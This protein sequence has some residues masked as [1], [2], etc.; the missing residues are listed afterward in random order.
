LFQG[1]G[2]IELNFKLDGKMDEFDEIDRLILNG[3]IEFAGKDSETGELLYRP[4][5]RLKEI[6]SRLCED[7][8]V[9]FSDITLILW[10]KKFLDM[11]ITE[12]DPLVRL[13]EKS[14]DPNAIRSLEKNERVVIEQIIK[15]LFNKN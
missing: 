7:L 9:Y 10:Q 3:G 12:K 6:D 11:D 4:T 2:R 14:F 8:S 5:D 15:A 13:A 1:F